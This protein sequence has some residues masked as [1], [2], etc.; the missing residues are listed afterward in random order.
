MGAHR[1]DKKGRCFVVFN[2]EAFAQRTPKSIPREAYYAWGRELLPRAMSEPSDESAYQAQREY[3]WRGAEVFLDHAVTVA[4]KKAGKLYCDD[5]HDAAVEA[6]CRAVLC[7]DPKRAQAMFET[8]LYRCVINAVRGVM[9][10][11]RQR[12]R[13]L[14]TVSMENVRNQLNNCKEAVYH[15]HD[16]AQLI[17]SLGLTAFER[18]VMHMRHVEGLT[19]EVIGHRYGVTK[20]TVHG[21]IHRA[22]AKARRNG[23]EYGS[24]GAH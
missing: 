24:Q 14:R 20:S 5:M 6:A 2:D 19:L 13:R 16:H 12:Q 3:M 10:K 1:V 18:K 23:A 7:Y 8:Y 17:E 9:A 21:W 4:Q 22:T 11:E 15:E